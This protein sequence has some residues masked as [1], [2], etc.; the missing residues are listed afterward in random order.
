MWTPFLQLLDSYVEEC[1]DGVSLRVRP[2]FEGTKTYLGNSK[3]M[4]IMRDH[5]DHK[6]KN[7]A[8][9]CLFLSY[10]L[11]VFTE[12][13]TPTTDTTKV[14]PPPISFLDFAPS[15]IPH[16]NLSRFKLVFHLYRPLLWLI[17]SC[18]YSAQMI[19]I[20]FSFRL[21]SISGGISTGTSV[22]L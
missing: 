17:I 22:R 21:R 18:I 20:Q 7:P 15:R 11:V 10:I 12:I 1:W 4:Y 5:R 16:V 2:E 8:V 14:A 3:Y 13:V 6:L 19:A 9:V